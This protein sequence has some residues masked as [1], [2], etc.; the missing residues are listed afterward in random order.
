M[1]DGVILRADVY[2]PD[3]EEPAP[4]V[5]SRTPYDR[6][7]SMTPSAAVDPELL[8]AAGIALVCQ[9]VRGRH[10]SDGEFYPL[11]GEAADGVDTIAWVAAQPWCN[12]RVGMAGRSY[13]AAA[14]WLAAA[15]A[16]P[17]LR[18]ISPVV[19]PN[20]P[21]HGWIYQGGAFELGFSL[22]WVQLLSGVKTKMPREFAHLPLTEAP[23]LEKA[24]A[25]F[26][27]DW[28][29][30]PT[31]DEYWQQIAI[32]FRHRRV[33][34]PS[35]N[36]GGWY[37]IFLGGTL[38][39]FRQTRE[40]AVSEAARAGARLLVGPW[41]HGTAFGAYPDHQ[42]RVFGEEAHLDVTAR[43]VEFF[44]RHL[45]G[46][47]RL[48]ER[49]PVEIFVMGANR[50]R[51]EQ[52]WP[53][54][55][56]REERWFLRAGETLDR[57]APGEEEPDAYD[58]DPRDPAP[59]RGGPTLLPGRF[60]SINA[61]PEDQRELEARDDV[62][63]YSSPPLQR[64]LEVTGPVRARLYVSSSARDADFV[65][66][67]CDVGEDGFSR[68]LCEGVLRARYRD[69]FTD[70]QPLEP[71]GVYALD[72]DLVATS[73][74]FRPG[75]RIRVSVTSSSFPRFDRNAG[76]AHAPGA[77]DEAQ[78]LAARQIVFHDAHRASHVVLPLV[79]REG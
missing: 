4:A 53:P 49:A 19:C 55:G 16:P 44:A 7:V 14:Q 57:H 11:T 18:A 78:L 45:G 42:W 75:H 67:L 73:N 38:Q 3:A 10:G 47:E 2:R 54:P 56:A 39:N 51:E 77:D 5:L 79:E 64:A 12:G 27:R 50:W 61:G 9:D 46:D 24:G 21:Y 71:G 36:V 31:D 25:G 70:P 15:E 68:I 62:L 37:D 34:V 63:V 43:L 32:D 30:H 8:S 28:L 74:C 41:G 59:T 60:M 72:V 20:H 52:D 33:G 26:Y 17:A 23:L 22:F 29:A 6:S 58:F 48:A 76:T 66:K 65:V 1:R 40:E 35:L 13:G 69:G